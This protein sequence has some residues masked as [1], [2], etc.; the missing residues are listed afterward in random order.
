MNLPFVATADSRGIVLGP[1]YEISATCSE[2]E[3]GA[4]SLDQHSTPYA[5]GL[6]VRI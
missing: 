2:A 4:L 1:A 6:G 5:T 3:A